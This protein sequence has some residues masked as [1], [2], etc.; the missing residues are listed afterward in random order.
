MK[1]KITVDAEAPEDE[2]RE[3][4]LAAVSRTLEGKE[5]RKVVVVKGRLVNIVVG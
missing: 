3:T 4:A 2:I 1:S 5:V